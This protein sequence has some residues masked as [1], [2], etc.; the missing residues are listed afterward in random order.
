MDSP[1][2]WFTRTTQLPKVSFQLFLFDQRWHDGPDQELVGK[3]ADQEVAED[4]DE[5]NP[6]SAAK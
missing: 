6:P 1:R 4:T 2:V 3:R 5:S